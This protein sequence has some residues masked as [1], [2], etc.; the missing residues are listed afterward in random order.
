MLNTRDLNMD[1]NIC[2]YN[3]F[4]NQETKIKVE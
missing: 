3:F 4:Y 2:D 1:Q